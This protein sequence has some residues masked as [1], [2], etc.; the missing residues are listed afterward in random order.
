MV[1][2]CG[3]GVAH[4]IEDEAGEVD[5]GAFQRPSGVE[6]GE[7]EEV[8]HQRR[9]PLGLRGDAGQ[10]VRRL[11]RQRS[12]AGQ[13]GVAADRREGGAQ[14]VA[15]VRDELAQ[16]HL[17]VLPG[18]QG[19][20]D[21]VEHVVERGPDL[22]DFGGRVG[23]G[24]PFGELDLAPVEREGADAPGRRGDPFEGLQLA[25]HQHGADHARDGQRDRGDDQLGRHQVGHRLLELAFGEAG[26]LHA[27][28]EAGGR[29]DPVGAERGQV[30]RHRA[31][32]R[33]HGEHRSEVALRE[34]AVAAATG[35]HAGVGDLAIGDRDGD[36]VRRAAPA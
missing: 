16:L 3:V 5:L 9:H 23:V 26:D 17:A 15:G 2:A 19:G 32:A 6:A 28:V 10:G 14:L 24:H 31:G 4:G 35:A 27:A 12:A 20:A 7:Q 36:D 21:V 22:A 30:E 25:A 33:R 8:L 1:R 11:V 18:L 13:L 34:G 29:D